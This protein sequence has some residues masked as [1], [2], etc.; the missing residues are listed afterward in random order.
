MFDG[1]RIGIR[2]TWPLRSI[3]FQARKDVAD[4]LF[5]LTCTVGRKA[6][7]ILLE[8]GVIDIDR[9]QDTEDI[10]SCLQPPF[11][12]TLGR[13]VKDRLQLVRVETTQRC[14]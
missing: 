5:A 4:E 12:Q 10:S 1:A 9:P 13:L 7:K 14:T 6:R 11:E 2:I 8:A 3:G